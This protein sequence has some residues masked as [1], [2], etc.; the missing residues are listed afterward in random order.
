MGKAS[1]KKRPV[2]AK[3]R[4]SSL[5][6]TLVI[7]LIV[8]TG[9]AGI[10]LSRGGGDSAADSAGPKIGDHWHATLGVNLCGTWQANTPTYEAPTGVHSHGDAFMHIHPFSSAGAGDNATIGLFYSQAD[11]KVSTSALEIG[12]EKYK[13]G[14]ACENIDKKAGKVRWS[15]NGQE[16]TGNPAD[17]I[18]KDRDV[19]ALAFLPDGIDIGTPPAASTASTPSDVGS[20]PP[21]SG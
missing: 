4:K 7:S 14:D 20:A 5:G 18:P 8:M 21:P 13:N 11:E 19:V 1:R 16:Q 6:F 9:V 12:D 3:A 17:Y 10:A 15:V 2:K